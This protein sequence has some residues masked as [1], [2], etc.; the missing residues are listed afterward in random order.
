MFGD[1][2]RGRKIA[3]I[4]DG[5]GVLVN[6][7]LGFCVKITET[8]EGRAALEVDTQPIRGGYDGPALRAFMEKTAVAWLQAVAPHRLNRGSD[9]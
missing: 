1:T 3:E 7:N 4:A 8:P 9:Y 5:K 2:E 6:I